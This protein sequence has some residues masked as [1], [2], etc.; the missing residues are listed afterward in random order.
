MLKKLWQAAIPQSA[1]TDAARRMQF[2]RQWTCGCGAVLRIRAKDDRRDGPSNF[3]PFPAWHRRAGHSKVPSA[4]L[5]WSGLAA[6]RG[7][8]VERFVE[9]PAC[10]AGLTVAD[11]KAQRRG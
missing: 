8:R 2:V 10:Q 1:V 6:E 3:E 11:Y 9:C 4:E 5:T 7:W